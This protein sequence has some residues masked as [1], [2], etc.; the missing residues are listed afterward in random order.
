MRR[1]FKVVLSIPLVIAVLMVSICLVG[2]FTNAFLL[3]E[4]WSQNGPDGASYEFKVNTFQ[5]PLLKSKLERGFLWGLDQ[6]RVVGS[7]GR[8]YDL[9]KDF[10]VNEYSGEVT[11]RWVIYGPPGAG[12]P[13]SGEYRFEFIR[14][15]QVI[16]TRSKKYTQSN[17]SWPT[18]VGWERRGGDLYVEWTPPDGAKASMWY[19]VLVW[20][21]DDTPE[22]FISQVFKGD[23]RDAVLEDVPFV[24]GGLYVLNVAIFFNT[25]YAYSEMYDFTW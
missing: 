23:A 18:D 20:S 9:Y 19:K 21:R 10:N 15:S 5:C 25:G 3:P 8:T 16:L 1:L 2:Q 4:V 22:L 7:D 13:L 6:V 12:L 17:I 14:D 11:R 24:E